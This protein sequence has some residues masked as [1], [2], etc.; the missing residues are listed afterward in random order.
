MSSETYY[1]NNGGGGLKDYSPE[2]RM[3][4]R[5]H[6]KTNLQMQVLGPC[7]GLSCAVAYIFLINCHVNWDI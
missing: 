7:P 1:R 4:T 6:G 3:N 2:M 5:T